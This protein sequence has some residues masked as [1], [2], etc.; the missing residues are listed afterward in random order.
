MIL[1]FPFE[2]YAEPFGFV[3]FSNRGISIERHL[4]LYATGSKANRGRGLRLE[5]EFDRDGD[6]GG[7]W[8]SVPRGRFVL[9]LL[10]CCYGSAL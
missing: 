10:E 3:E 9:V 8:L 6:V 4:R 1:G 5:E 7:D 2:T